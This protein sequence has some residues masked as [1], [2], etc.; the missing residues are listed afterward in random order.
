ME[1]DTKYKP[2]VEL[3]AL[4]LVDIAYKRELINKETYLCVLNNICWQLPL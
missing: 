4:I 2:N 3:A 1:L